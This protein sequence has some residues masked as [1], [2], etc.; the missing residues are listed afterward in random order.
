MGTDVFSLAERKRIL[1]DQVDNLARDG[2]L[3]CGAVDGNG[4]GTAEAWRGAIFRAGPGAL[5]TIQQQLN[6]FEDVGC[7]VRQRNDDMRQRDEDARRALEPL[8]DDDP[9]F[10]EAR[11]LAD[12]AAAIAQAAERPMTAGQ[13]GE[14]IA[15]QRDILWATRKG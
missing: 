3:G 5:A 13:A 7:D 4:L 9:E 15:V 10:V 11:R 8:T 12:E 1:I 6:N 14:L 2:H